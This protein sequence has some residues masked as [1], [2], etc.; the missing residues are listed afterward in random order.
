MDRPWV[1][2]H[3]RF[4]RLG[5]GSGAAAG[6]ASLAPP[7]SCAQPASASIYIIIIGSRPLDGQLQGQ[8]PCFAPLLACL[9]QAGLALCGILLYSWVQQVLCMLCSEQLQTPRHPTEA[10][11]QFK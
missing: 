4:W 2:G 3:T 7:R 9:H 6:V 1:A 5:A 11:L 8:L 10:A